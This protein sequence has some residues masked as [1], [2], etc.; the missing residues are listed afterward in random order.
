MVWERIYKVEME[1]TK[2]LGVVFEYY[3]YNSDCGSVKRLHR[4]GCLLADYHVLF[5]ELKALHNQVFN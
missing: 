3:Q 2:K 5:Q 1:I 4:W